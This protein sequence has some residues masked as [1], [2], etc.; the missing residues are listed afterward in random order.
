MAIDRAAPCKHGKDGKN[1]PH[2]AFEDG[3]FDYTAE[4]LAR[5]EHLE[6]QLVNFEQ[7]MVAIESPGII[8]EADDGAERNE[9]EE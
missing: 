4:L 5:I 9:E 3:M 8:E 1:C 2:C 7:R 6:M